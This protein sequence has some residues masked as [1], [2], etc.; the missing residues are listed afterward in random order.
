MASKSGRPS[1]AAW[2]R[3]AVMNSCVA[4][5]T[6]AMPSRS[7]VNESCKLHVVHDPQSAKPSTTASALLRRSMTASGA[8]FANVGF[9][10][11]STR[12]TP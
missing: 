4:T 6:A 12:P 7:S 11:R 5:G 3:A 2:A 9:A 1:A 8:G 10:S